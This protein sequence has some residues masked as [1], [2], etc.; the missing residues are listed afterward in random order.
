MYRYPPSTIYRYLD[1][2]STQVILRIHNSHRHN[3]TQAIQTLVQAR[4]QVPIIHIHHPHHRNSNADT[5]PT[6]PPP[7]RIDKAQT[8][9]SQPL[10]PL[11]PRCPSQTQTHLTYSTYSTYLRINAE[12]EKCICERIREVGRET[13]KDGLNNTERE[14]E[15]VRMK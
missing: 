5:R 14:K 4:C 12:K 3:A 1:L 6:P 8:Q 13:W 15:H 11:H 9:S 7:H 2:S 10:T